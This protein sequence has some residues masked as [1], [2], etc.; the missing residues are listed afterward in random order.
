MA[1]VMRAILVLFLSLLLALPAQDALAKAKHK[2]K[3]KKRAKVVKI[4]R[5]PSP[6]AKE[7]FGRQTQ[8]APLAARAIGGYAK[9]C[10]MGAKALPIDGP[11]WQAMRLSRN[12]NWG[13][14]VLV[15]YVERLAKEAQKDDGWSGLMVGDLAQP[16]GGP[17]LTGHASHQIGLDA[18]IWLM[19]MP[20]HTLSPLERENLS[21]VSML[22]EDGVSVDRKI[23]TPEHVKLIKRAASYKDVSRIFVHPAIKKALCTD[24]PKDDREWLSKVRPWWGHHYHFHVRLAC[25]SGSAGCVNQPKAGPVDGCGKEVDNWLKKMRKRPTPTPAPQAAPKKPLKPRRQMTLAD[26]P[27][28]CQS[29]VASHVTAA[30]TAVPMEAVPMPVR[31]P[32]EL[33]QKSATRT[34]G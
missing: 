1:S 33:V 20:N 7:V 30:D 14:P 8:P 9:G 21:A 29:M 19:Q 4:M 23:W 5:P 12:R 34:G 26:M 24:A 31:K 22:A 25:P 10:L 17:M 3:G 2:V 32:A 18:D 28:D 6:V 27:A 11:A 15:S 16:M 13:H